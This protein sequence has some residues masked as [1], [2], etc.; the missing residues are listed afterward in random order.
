MPYPEHHSWK[1]SERNCKGKVL[2]FIYLI[3]RTFF[4]VFW[5]YFLPTI[6]ILAQFIFTTKYVNIPDG[7]DI[8]IE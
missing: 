4:V 2:R 1:L 5:Y 6:S 8:N 7:L 3:L